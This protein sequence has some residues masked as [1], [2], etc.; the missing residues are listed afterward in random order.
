MLGPCLCLYIL[1][2]RQAAKLFYGTH[3]GSVPV[4]IYLHVHQAAKLF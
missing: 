3:V 4:L 2:V 1:H